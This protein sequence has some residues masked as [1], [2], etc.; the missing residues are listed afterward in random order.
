VVAAVVRGVAH[1]GGKSIEKVLEE[2]YPGHEAVGI[3]AKADQTIGTTTGSGWA[4]GSR[5]DR[6]C[7]LPAG[8][9]R[10]FDLSRR[11]ATAASA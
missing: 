6:L 3:I 1:F 8:A 7:R 9:D 10:L 2:R 11:C 4:I 5:A